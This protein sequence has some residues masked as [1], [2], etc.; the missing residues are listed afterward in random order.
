MT[1]KQND[2]DQNCDKFQWE[3]NH[4]QCIDVRWLGYAEAML[5]LVQN[6]IG[7]S[8]NLSSNQEE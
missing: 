5:Q 7:I 1:V 3:R 2:K 4:R 8:T 6:A